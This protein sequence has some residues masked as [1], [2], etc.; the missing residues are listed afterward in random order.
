MKW[1]LTTLTLSATLMVGQTPN[2]LRAPDMTLACNKNMTPSD[3]GDSFVDAKGC[4]TGT[5]TY[6]WL[7]SSAITTDIPWRV[8]LGS[9]KAGH[10]DV[11]WDADGKG[12]CHLDI[13]FIGGYP[14][15]SC[16]KE[17]DD[18]PNSQTFRCSYRTNPG[19]PLSKV[20]PTA[21][22][23]LTDPS[24]CWPPKWVDRQQAQNAWIRLG[25]KDHPED[26]NSIV[27][28]VP[29]PPPMKPAAIPAPKPHG[30]FSLASTESYSFPCVGDC[31]VL[32]PSI[33]KI[34]G[35]VVL[36][37]GYLIVQAGDVLQVVTIEVARECLNHPNR[38]VLDK[39]R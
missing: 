17:K 38:C 32:D 28:N 16:V 9:F 23:W 27:D 37:K 19:P 5:Y 35:D 13:S 24:S 21:H 14:P 36:P 6:D 8:Y 25:L 2:P 11:D 39:G 29:P 18:H 34:V 15:I 31:R 10:C 7:N 30:D 3:E 22:A 1:L 4:I 33:Y 12:N 26:A 20:C